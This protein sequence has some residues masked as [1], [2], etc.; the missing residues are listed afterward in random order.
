MIEANVKPY[1]FVAVRYKDLLNQMV[2]AVYWIIIGG[3]TSLRDP[4]V[5]SEGFHG[6][7]VPLSS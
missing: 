3:V 1:R 6:S 4:V 7:I 2:V 5:D